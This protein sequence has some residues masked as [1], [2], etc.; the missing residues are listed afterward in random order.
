ML[1]MIIIG[2]G[3]VALALVLASQ[4]SQK[5]TPNAK[6]AYG[7]DNDELLLGRHCNDPLAG[8]T[9]DDLLLFGSNDIVLGGI[10]ADHSGIDEWIKP[11]A[12]TVFTDFEPGQDVLIFSHDGP[13]PNLAIKDDQDGNAVLLVDGSVAVTFRDLAAAFLNE[14]HL[15]LQQ[16]KA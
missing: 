2:L 11:N 6:V 12:S 15:I 5:H 8:G 3:L 16:R 9:S 14:S 10:D 7:A 13:A 1:A 4:V